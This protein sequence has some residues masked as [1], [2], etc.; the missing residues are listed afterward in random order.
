MFL[1][2]HSKVASISP[3]GLSQIV[4]GAPYRPPIVVLTK[5]ADEDEDEDDNEEAEEAEE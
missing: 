1:S 2:I 5:A 4:F 3:I